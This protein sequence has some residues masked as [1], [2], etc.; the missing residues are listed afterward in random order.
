ME[1]GVF[2]TGA[3]A[4]HRR[5]RARPRATLSR[6]TTTASLICSAATSPPSR[7]TSSAC[8]ATAWSPATAAASPSPGAGVP[9]SPASRS[10][11]RPDN[12]IGGESNAA[13]EERLLRGNC[14]IVAGSSVAGID[15]GGGIAGGEAP[16]ASVTVAGNWIGL[17]GDGDAASNKRRHRTSATAASWPATTPPARLIG[18]PDAERRQPHLRQ[19]DRRSTRRDGAG[20]A[21]RAAER[22]RRRPRPG[23]ARSRTPPR[24]RGSAAATAAGRDRRR[25]QLRRERRRGSS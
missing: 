18:G 7:A 16:A 24:T 2:V 23:D 11:R 13:I 4:Q 15:L 5:R 10:T 17:D 8:D 6:A 9:G 20:R 25:Q 19:R 22:L 12:V 1:R 3:S 21:D 14:N